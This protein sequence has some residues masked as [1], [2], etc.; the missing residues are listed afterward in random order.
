MKTSIEISDFLKEASFQPYLM[1]QTLLSMAQIEIFLHTQKT[2]QVIAN[3]T[4]LLFTKVLTQLRWKLVLR[5]RKSRSF[6]SLD[7]FPLANPITTTE[8]LLQ[9]EEWSTD[10]A[11]LPGSPASSGWC[12]AAESN[13]AL[14]A[15]S[16][17]GFLS[18]LHGI[19]RSLLL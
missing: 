4:F 5:H 3:R 17:S 14:S 16:L 10:V 8:Q 19:D 15:F 11:Q 12:T 13:L 2:S 1:N 18:K 9:E 7:F 6:Q